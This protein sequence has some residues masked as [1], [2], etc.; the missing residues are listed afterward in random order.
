MGGHDDWLGL[1]GARVL[2]AGAGGIGGACARAYA[3]AGAT[4]AVVDRDA[5]A[6]AALA[7]DG[8]ERFETIEADLTAHG[9]GERVTAEAIRRLGGID[10]LL[11]AVGINDRRPILEFTEEEW[12]RI[13]RV[14]LSTVF[15]LAQ[16]TGRHMVAQGHG[17]VLA[18]SSVSGLLAHH[19][20]GPYAA[21][22]GGINQLLRVMA[23]EWAPFGVTVNALA[24]G[25]IETPLTAAHLSTPGKREALESQVPAGRLGTTDELT[26]PA[27]FL[28][29]KHAGFVTGHVMYIDGGRTLV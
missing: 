28:S 1:S 10:V 17:R 27:L 14:N 24:P 26:G 18:L 13:V 6:L 2:V 16:A 8:E 21:T 3:R 15:S 23:H 4:V 11:H 20:H 19:S 9:E 22:K 7:A 25:Y 29:S 5:A 12:D